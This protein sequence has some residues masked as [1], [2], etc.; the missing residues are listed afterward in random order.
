M[1]NLESLDVSALPWLPLDERTAFPKQSEGFQA[2]IE[3]RF[4]I[5]CKT[6]V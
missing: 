3:I 5:Y 1:I 6:K 4:L 2:L